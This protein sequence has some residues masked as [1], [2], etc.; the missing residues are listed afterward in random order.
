MEFDPNATP[1]RVSE[2]SF[3]VVNP[4][5]GRIDLGLAGIDVPADCQAQTA[6]PPAQC[7]FNQYLESLDGFPTVAGARTPV[8]AALD[9]ATATVPQNVAVVEARSQRSI[10]DVMVSFEPT[11]PLPPDRPREELAG[12]RLHLDGRTGLRFG[13]SRRWQAGRGVGHLQPPEA[14]GLAHLRGERG[15]GH[16]G[17]LSLPRLCSASR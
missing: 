10:A 15:G 11:D 5:T 14:G 16:R 17:K 2:P 8:S 7:E 4:T 9:T 12:G 6:M 1:P 13:G 3:A